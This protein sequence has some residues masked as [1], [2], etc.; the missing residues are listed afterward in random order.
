M[1]EK[2]LKIGL[3]DIDSRIPNLALMKLSTYHKKLGD[4]V[5]WYS[6]LFH[7][8][9]DKIY[10]SKVFNFSD[11]GYIREDMEI[12]GSGFDLHKEL[13]HEIEHTYPDYSLYPKCDYALG[14][15]TRGCIRNCKFC[16]VPQKEGWIKKNADLEEF[17]QDQSKV[18][19]LDNNILALEDHVEEL[20]RLRKSKKKID[21]NQGLDIRLINHEN[22]S[23]LKE[24][25]RWK[26]LRLRFAF[27]NIKLKDIIEEKLNIF[28]DIGISQ[29]TI[30]FY[31]L[32]GYNS[33]RRED[34]IR[35]NFLKKNHID[36]FAMPYKNM[37]PYQKQFARWVN[38]H[39]FKYQT[40]QSYQ[41]KKHMEAC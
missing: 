15:I 27:D 4:F 18:M 23:I 37:D 5:E 12:G 34:L 16:I 6:P 19:L 24:I 35:I 2:A 17:C 41:N 32:I 8:T 13:P 29:G 22:A 9:Y 31:V 30:Q 33:T 40:F 20:D 10:G 3:Y 28:Q 1:N 14:F 11:K 7:A 25:K 38:R 39:Y 36:A 26:G 21:F